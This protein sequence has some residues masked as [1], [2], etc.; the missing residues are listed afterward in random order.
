MNQLVLFIRKRYKELIIIVLLLL[1][2]FGGAMFKKTYNSQR[3]AID[4]LSLANQTSKSFINRQNQVITQQTILIT[5]SQSSIKKYTDS[6]FNLNR[7][8]QRR[9][10]EVI[11]FYSEK[12]KAALADTVDIPYTDNGNSDTVNATGEYFEE[13]DCEEYI[14]NAIVGKIS[15]PK[16]VLL[17]SVGVFK[18]DATILEKGLRINKLEIPD[19]LSLRVVENKTGLFKPR[20]LDVQAKHSNPMFTTV[21]Q[22]SILYKPKPK[23]K[24]VVRA[25]ILG[26]GIYLGSKL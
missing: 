9:V 7:R 22:T 6:I 8:E 11:A 10:K 3:S 18:I 5:E 20:T 4:S 19:T 13:S 16:S 1:L 24:W 14:R 2:V 12:L 25:L 15:V 21:D 23:G 26:L 17:D